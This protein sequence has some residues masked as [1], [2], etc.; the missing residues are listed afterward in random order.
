MRPFFVYMIRCGDGSYYTG[1][2][3]DLERRWAEHQSGTFGGYTAKRQPLR[4]VYFEECGE[5]IDALERERQIKPWSRAKK[6][7]L[8]A[9]DRDLLHHLALG[10]DRQAPLDFARGERQAATDSDPTSGPPR[11]RSG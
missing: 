6:E 2:T 5:R 10:S 11:L 4:L 1:H 8:V 9:K 7:A 3:D